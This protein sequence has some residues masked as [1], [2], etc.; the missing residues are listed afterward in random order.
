MRREK[1]H[2]E[3]S[4]AEKRKKD[5]QFGKMIKTVIQYKKKF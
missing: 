3:S 4:I 1:I 2:F 5:K